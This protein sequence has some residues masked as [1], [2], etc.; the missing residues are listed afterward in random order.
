MTRTNGGVRSSLNTWLAAGQPGS[1]HHV[2]ARRDWTSPASHPKARWA[3]NSFGFGHFP[4]SSSELE[5]QISNQ[6]V[7]T[8]NLISIPLGRCLRLYQDRDD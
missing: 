1:L 5:S 3:R 8:F 4:W 6:S 7:A 2:S